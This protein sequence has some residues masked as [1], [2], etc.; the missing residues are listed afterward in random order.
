M[1]TQMQELLLKL[2]NNQ[3]DF[4]LDENATLMD[5]IS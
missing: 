2:G 5:S 4:N 3:K 1:K